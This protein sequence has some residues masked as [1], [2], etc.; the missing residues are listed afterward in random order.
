MA[1]VIELELSPAQHAQLE[2]MAR[3]RHVPVGEIVQA[4]VSEWLDDQAQLEHARKV[5]RELGRG[6]DAS[7]SAGDIAQNHDQYLYSR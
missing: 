4:A 6:L 1:M 3:T 5:M 7:N 2:D